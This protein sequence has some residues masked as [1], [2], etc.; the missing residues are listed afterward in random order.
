[1]QSQRTLRRL[2]VRFLLI[3]CT[4]LVLLG[5]GTHFLHALQV[6]RNARGFLTQADKALADGNLQK[7]KEYLSR[8]VALVPDD[9]GNLAKYGLLLADDKASQTPKTVLHAF[10]VL[11]KVLRIDAT[12]SDVRRRVADLAMHP[13]LRRF[14]DAQEHLNILI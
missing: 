8:Y 9:A 6:N 10:F 3:L 14:G 13:W 1:M 12:R 11:E 5:V 2:N 4:S 7:A